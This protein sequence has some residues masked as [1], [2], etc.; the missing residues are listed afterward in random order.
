MLQ[1]NEERAAVGKGPVG[2]INPV[3]YSQA[4][5]RAVNDIVNGSNSGCESHGFPAV[6][7]WDP[8][9]GTC[10]VDLDSSPALRARCDS[11]LTPTYRSWNPE[12]PGVTKAVHES[13]LMH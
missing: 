3:L 2:F 6:P 7:G 11:P 13:A 8:S 9:S 4:G 5:I 12:L 10:C 1:I